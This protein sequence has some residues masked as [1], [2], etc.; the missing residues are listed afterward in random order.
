MKLVQLHALG[1]LSIINVDEW[2]D[3]LESIANCTRVKSTVFRNHYY[4]I[5]V[6]HY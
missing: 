6:S 1:A 4:I 3:A 2:I 5:Q